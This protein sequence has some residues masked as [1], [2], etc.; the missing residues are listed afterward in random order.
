LTFDLQLAIASLLTWVQKF[1]IRKTFSIIF[2]APIFQPLSNPYPAL[3]PN[4]KNLFLVGRE[5][6]GGCDETAIAS[7]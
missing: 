7:A 1:P 6:M 3:A 5:R 2:A 4:K